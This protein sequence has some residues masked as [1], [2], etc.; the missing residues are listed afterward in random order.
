MP[1]WLIWL[2]PV[3]VMTLA[4]MAWATW[5][6]RSRG[7]VA[8]ADSVRAHERFRAA[9]AAPMPGS[10]RAASQDHRRR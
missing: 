6:N 9:L 2:L 1:A 7:P 3:P 4:A 10:Q 5:T 8:A